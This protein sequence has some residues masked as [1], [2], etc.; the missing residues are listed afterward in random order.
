[1]GDPIPVDDVGAEADETHVAEAKRVLRR[2]M[3]ELRRE[4]GSDPARSD[5][6]ADELVSIVERRRATG[7]PIS[8]VVSFEAVTG[9]PDLGRF[10]QWCREAAVEVVRPDPSP[11]AVAP[12]DPEV[13]D[14]IVVPGLAFTRD[15]RR[16][17][18][19]GGWYDRFLAARRTDAL[20]IGV[21]FAEQLRDDLPVAGHDVSV[22]VVAIGEGRAARGSLHV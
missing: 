4:I 1:M 8:V 9:E 6:I 11:D 21:C 20:V 16:L 7:T 3:R 10:E 22:D 19:G 2:R 13:P 17:G 18:Q 14:V 15:G 12:V 5:A